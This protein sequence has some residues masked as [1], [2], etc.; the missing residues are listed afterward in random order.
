MARIFITNIY[1]FNKRGPMW[2]ACNFGFFLGASEAIDDEQ[3]S[4]DGNRHMC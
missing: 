1:T 4:S 3:N 2:L